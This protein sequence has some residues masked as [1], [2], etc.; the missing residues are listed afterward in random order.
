[1]AQQGIDRA[2]RGKSLHC[3]GASGVDRRHCG[4]EYGQFC[5]YSF[6]PAVFHHSCRGLDR[7]ASGDS[8]ARSRSVHCRHHVVC[9]GGCHQTAGQQ[10]RSWRGAVLCRGGT[11]RRRRDWGNHRPY[12]HL[13]ASAAA[14]DHHRRQRRPVRPDLFRLN[15]RVGPITGDDGKLFCRG[16]SLRADDRLGV[17]GGGGRYSLCLDVHY[18]RTPISLR[19]AS[20]RRPLMRWVCR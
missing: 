3:H 16:V 8:A 17:V 2:A 12:R 7:A 4:A 9:C 6:Y 10:H 18:D 5:G 13:F 19:S 20:I 15:R 1:M 11:C 14:C